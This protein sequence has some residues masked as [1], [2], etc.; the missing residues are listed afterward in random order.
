MDTW[1]HPPNSNK[2]IGIEDFKQIQN[3][4]ISETSYV[5]PW[6]VVGISDPDPWSPNQALRP[7]I[8]FNAEIL[9]ITGKSASRFLL[10]VN[11][12]L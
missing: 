4:S 12:S 10:A 8:G 3:S 5:G 6:F 11:I 1:V 9:F 2:S 7:H